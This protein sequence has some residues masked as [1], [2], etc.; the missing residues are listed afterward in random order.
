MDNIEKTRLIEALEAELAGIDESNPGK[1]P[2]LN[3]N[4]LKYTDNLTLIEQSAS[5]FSQYIDQPAQCRKEKTSENVFLKALLHSLKEPLSVAENWL[6]TLSNDIASLEEVACGNT[7]L[8]CLQMGST[9]ETSLQTIAKKLTDCIQELQEAHEVN[10]QL[11]AEYSNELNILAEDEKLQ[12]GLPS[13]SWESSANNNLNPTPGTPTYETEEDT[14]IE[15]EMNYTPSRKRDLQI[16]NNTSAFLRTPTK[17][18]V[19]F[20]VHRSGSLFKSPLQFRKRAPKV[21]L[22]NKLEMVITPFKNCVQEKLT[23]I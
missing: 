5:D 4:V 16:S 8:P 19:R 1:S 14:D 20:N 7:K 6:N 3:S 11:M 9:A 22:S 23:F 18:I 10:C 21:S 13:L 15:M 17:R 12:S 2:N